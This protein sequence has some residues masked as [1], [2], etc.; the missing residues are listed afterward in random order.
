M[1]IPDDLIHAA[2]F[3]VDIVGLSNPSM[4]T[5]T[6]TAKIKTLNKF[7]EESEIIKNTK[8]DEL[9]ILPSGDGMFLGFVDGLEQPLQLAIEL[10][11][12]ILQFNKEK[13]KTSYEKIGVRIGCHVGNVFLV[14]DMSGI[15]NVWGP[16]IIMARRVMDL[17]DEGH[18]LMTAEMAE[19]LLEINNE[20]ANILHPIHDYRIKHGQTILLYSVFSSTFGNSERP[21]KGFVEI[22][23]FRSSL[24]HLKKI[25]HHNKI[26]LDYILNNYDTNVIQCS[27]QYCFLNKSDEPIFTMTNYV[28]TDNALNFNELELDIRDKNNNK[29]NLI[30]IGVDTEHNKEFTFKFI[31]PIYSNNEGEYSV[32]FTLKKRFRRIEHYFF[33]GSEQLEIKFELQ[34]NL[35]E[36]NLIYRM[37]DGLS[38]VLEPKFVKKGQKNQF[39]WKRNMIKPGDMIILEWKQN[40]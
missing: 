35:I 36:P 15:E 12:K 33:F 26:E 16:G 11:K 31:E 13:P 23:K 6:Q 38:I 18:I 22:P 9:I 20:Y 3:Y 5:S 17:G 21:K 24:P 32:S 14:N 27:R 37:D 1:S 10:Q 40:L 2:F 19:S 34:S 39:I 8:K 28:V 7:L 30:N 29:L 4:S 25:I